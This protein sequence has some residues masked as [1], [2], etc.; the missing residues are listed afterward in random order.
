MRPFTQWEHTMDFI[1]ENIE[2]IV[3]AVVALLGIAALIAERTK[4]EKDNKVV[5][6]LLK[7]VT[8]L[9]VVRARKV[10]GAV[11]D[12]IAKLRGKGK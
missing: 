5:A 1:T 9:D 3:A 4:T 7:I 6:F 11:V 12:G 10:I 8:A 2:A